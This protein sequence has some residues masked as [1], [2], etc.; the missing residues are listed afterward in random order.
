MCQRKLCKHCSIT[1]RIHACAVIH[2]DKQSERRHF[3][4]SLYCVET[5]FHLLITTVIIINDNIIQFYN[6]VRKFMWQLCRWDRD[7]DIFLTVQRR[8]ILKIV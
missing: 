8:E 1:I 4:I 2:I 7:D 6:N 3:I 5:E